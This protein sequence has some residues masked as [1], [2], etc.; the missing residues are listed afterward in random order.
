MNNFNILPKIDFNYWY[1]KN[2]IDS[3]SKRRFVSMIT[4]INNIFE[5]DNNFKQAYFCGDYDEIIRLKGLNYNQLENEIII[6]IRN[7]KNVAD[8][9]D[10]EILKIFDL[11]QIWGGLT[12]GSNPYQVKNNN[13]VR[14]KYEN[15]IREYRKLINLSVIQN[16]DSYKFVK[17]KNI[18]CLNMSFGSKHISFWSRKENDDNCLVVI[19]NKISGVSGF[20]IASQANFKLIIESIYEITNELNLKPY[21]IEKALF[22]F[23]KFYFDNNNSKFNH[24]ERN[25][26]DYDVA[27][28][29]KNKLKIG[30]TNNSIDSKKSRKFKQKSK[31]LISKNNC[32]KVNNEVYIS[33][34]YISNTIKI[35]ALINK[36]SSITKGKLI[37]YKY[38]GDNDRLEIN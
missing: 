24:L 32:L 27:H 33:I 6:L 36:L 22:T 28:D 5:K 16:I 23:H 15:W 29:L 20:K 37:F 13:T 31:F 19:D 2:L 11:I 35:K 18:P 26:I 4:R 17:E 25:S 7:Q 8:F 10:M 30:L 3:N 38:I 34:D 1:H 9:S 14:L 21:Q 12:G